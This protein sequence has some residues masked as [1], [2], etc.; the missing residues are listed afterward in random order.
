MRM[1]LGSPVAVGAELKA[2]EEKGQ[3][4]RVDGA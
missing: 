1:R 4:G 2:G 3:E